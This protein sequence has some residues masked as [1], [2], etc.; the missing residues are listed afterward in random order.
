MVS[1]ASTLAERQGFLFRAR[2]RTST[3]YQPDGC[4]STL[5]FECTSIPLQCVSF[6][7]LPPRMVKHLQ[8]ILWII[9]LVFLYFMDTSAE[10]TSLCVFR[11]LGLQSC[12]GCGLGHAV[13]AALHLDLRQALQAHILGIPTTMAI[14]YCIFKHLFSH[15]IKYP[16]D[17]SATKAYDATG[18]SAR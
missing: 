16:Y 7:K 1:K 17:G 11:F 3:V 2:N 13:H 10:T 4:I 18:H 6:P 15:K 5:L 9:A 14:I 12:P 8:P